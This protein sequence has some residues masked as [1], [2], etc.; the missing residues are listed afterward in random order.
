MAGRSPPFEKQ[1]RDGRRQRRLSA[2]ADG[3][4]ADADDGMAQTRA[5]VGSRRVALAA[6]PHGRRVD[7]AQ[8]AGHR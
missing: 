3:Q 1:P 6:P 5:Q 7:R 4:V 8:A 2:A